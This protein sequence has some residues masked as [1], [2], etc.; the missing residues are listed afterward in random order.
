MLV[1]GP[2]NCA[3]DNLLEGL[4]SLRCC[5]IRIGSV[6]RA[7]SSVQSLLLDNVVRALNADELREALEDARKCKAQLDRARKKMRRDGQRRE[8]ISAR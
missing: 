5:A 3:V 2:S 7:S 8:F 4:Q 1:T 6:A